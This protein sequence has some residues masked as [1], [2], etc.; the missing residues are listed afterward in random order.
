MHSRLN[1]ILAMKLS[2]TEKQLHNTD[3]AMLLE[4]PSEVSEMIR[5][6]Q[7]EATLSSVVDARL[8]MCLPV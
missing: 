3:L 8:F 6:L 7:S 4:A 2:Q 1:R 5:L